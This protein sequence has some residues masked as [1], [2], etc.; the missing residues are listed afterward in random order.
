MRRTRV[1]PYQLNRIP[2]ERLD[3]YE[4]LAN[5]CYSS[6]RRLLRGICLLGGGV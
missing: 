5:L 4:T 3:L 6:R 2:E 1:Y